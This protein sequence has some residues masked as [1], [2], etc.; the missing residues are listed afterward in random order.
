MKPVAASRSQLTLDATTVTRALAII[1]LALVALSTIALLA[2]AMM[3]RSAHDVRLAQFFYVD[4][5][6]NIPTAFSV[7]LLLSCA[8]LLAAIAVL[9]RQ[10]ARPVL[11][12]TV[13]SVGFA[14][15]AVDEGWSFHERLIQPVRALM[16]GDR[17]GIFYY[18]WVVPALGLVTLLGLFF[19][20]FL[21]RL[22][23]AT[24]LR[25]IAAGAIYVSGAVGVELI[26]GWVDQDRGD[27]NVVS[28]LIGTLQETLEMTGCIAFIRALLLYITDTCPQVLVRFTQG[29]DHAPPARAPL[30]PVAPARA[31]AESSGPVAAS[32]P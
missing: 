24:R 26:E 12:W 18:A 1:A 19:L 25:F 21:L 17:P 28:G 7:F 15:M 30:T 9:E 2:S 16:G 27:R 14:L 6:R 29:T 32:G 22:S 31:T 5:E 8:V 3:G 23:P 11:Y 13:L 20:R 4:G 10:Q